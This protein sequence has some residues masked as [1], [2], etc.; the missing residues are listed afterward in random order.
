VA[1]TGRHV[2]QKS[3]DLPASGIG[4]TVAVGS[5]CNLCMT[6]SGLMKDGESWN[7]V[8][9]CRGN[10]R[11]SV[12]EESSSLRS[13]EHEQMRGVAGCRW[14]LE[15]FRAYRDAGDLG[16]AEVEGCC[17]KVYC[18]GLNAFSDEAIGEAGHGIGF[19]GHGGDAKR[20]GGGHA[21]TGC[22]STYTEDNVRL[23]IANESATGEQ[24][25]RQ[26]EHGF[27][28]GGERDIVEGTDFD[29]AELK[30]GGGHE[31]GFHATRGA[32]EEDFG[33]VPCNKFACDC[34]SGDDVAARASTSDED[35]DA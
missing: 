23:E 18:R 19:E 25:A 12:I 30:A 35:T 21:R 13:A 22:V 4:S 26:I 5:F 33:G 11:K 2:V 24:A 7:G 29:Q 8:E 20:E 28:A 34:E 6:G 3:A 10:R 27:D 15:K 17:G 32:E 16:I 31:P 9:Q 1:E 14:Q